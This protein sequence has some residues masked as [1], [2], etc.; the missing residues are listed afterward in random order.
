[1]REKGTHIEMLPLTRAIWRATKQTAKLFLLTWGWALFIAAGVIALVLSSKFNFNMPLAFAG[2]LVGL[3][4]VAGAVLPTKRVWRA[5][6]AHA[7]QE[8]R[9]WDIADQLAFD[10]AGSAL[11]DILSGRYPQNAHPN[12]D[13]A[14]HEVLL[15]FIRKG[16]VRRAIRVAQY[17]VEED[18]REEVGDEWHSASTIL[19]GL[20]AD[21]GR[22]QVALAMCRAGLVDVESSG[23]AWSSSRITYLMVM[24]QVHID[25]HQ[26]PESKKWL[27]SVKRDIDSRRTAVIDNKLDHFVY[28]TVH[29]GRSEVDHAYF[30]GF[31]AVSR[32]SWEKTTPSVR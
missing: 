32:P 24:T 4:F 12:L 3:F 5:F 21:I 16:E 22:F 26:I 8:E 7:C 17:I 29:S 1:M 30:C 9:L 13:L 25:L 15:I 2:S 18:K 31:K 23:S 14:L 19:A 28:E 11:D 10:D 27:K 20:Y 6:L